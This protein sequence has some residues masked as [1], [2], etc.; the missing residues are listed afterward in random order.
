MEDKYDFIWVGAKVKWN[1]P[2]INDYDPEDREW[3]ANI[4]W[5][6]DGIVGAD[7]D[8]VTSDCDIILISSEYSE[9][10]VY[11]SELEPYKSNSKHIKYEQS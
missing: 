1:D 8:T 4:E 7:E 2:G 3:K 9:A 6:V 10:E 5:T 11:P